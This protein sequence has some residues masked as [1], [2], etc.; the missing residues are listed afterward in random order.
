MTTVTAEEARKK[1]SDIMNRAA[2][3]HEPTVLTR[4]GKGI[5]AVVSMEDYE[6]L[7]ELIKQA[8]DEADLKSFR[9]AMKEIKEGKTIPLEKVMEEL[10]L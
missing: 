2:Y 10:G 6:L 9:R 5:A 8:E 7:Q 4:H 3:K 1:L